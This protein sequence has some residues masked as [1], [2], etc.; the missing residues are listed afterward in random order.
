V[1]YESDA[2][3]GRAFWDSLLPRIR[4]L[5]GVTAATMNDQPPLMWDW[6]ALPP[7]TID[8]QPDP[9]PGRWPALT[10]QMVSADYFR[11]MQFPILQGR[12]FNAQDT[13]DKGNVIIVDNALAER[14][15][16]GQSPLGKGM[17]VQSWDGPRHCTIVGAVQ[18]VR[19]K[20]AGQPENSF[21]GYLSYTQW[22]LDRVWLI[23]RSAL[24]SSTLAPAIRST[25]ASIDPDIPVIDTRTYDDLISEKFVTR[26]LCAFLVTLFSGAALF[27]SSIGLYGI[28]AYAVGQRTRRPK[29]SA[30][31]KEMDHGDTDAN[32][33][34]TDRQDKS[35][36]GPREQ[37]QRIDNRV[38][39]NL[40][41]RQSLNQ[42]HF[43]RRINGAIALRSIRLLGHAIQNER[44]D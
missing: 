40:F 34:R 42:C 8:G 25:V 29:R 39:M 7:F 37:R 44:G 5:P 43:N 28:L 16:P 26:R 38:P 33:Q 24:D 35:K 27:L 6:E 13:I 19:F 36:L 18:H 23:L 31:E 3:K 15:F 22:G 17:T 4:Q 20:S 1:R 41:Q 21:Q 11:T 2:A 30:N 10:W 12:D 9:G 32:A 14:Y